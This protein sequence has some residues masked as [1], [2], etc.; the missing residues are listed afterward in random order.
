MALSGKI[1]IDRGGDCPGPN[2][3]IRAVW[4][5]GWGTVLEGR[6][7]PVSLKSAAD[8]SEG[9]DPGLYAQAMRVAGVSL[10]S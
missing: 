2:A 10:G 8:R 1:G 4:A 9:I 5:A 3:A 7:V 6:I